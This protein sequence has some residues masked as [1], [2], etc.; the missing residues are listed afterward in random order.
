MIDHQKARA[1]GE[2]VEWV[3]V[4]D[5]YKAIG[6][7]VRVATGVRETLAMLRDA[8]NEMSRFPKVRYGDRILNV[9]YSPLLYDERRVSREI[10]ALSKKGAKY[11]VHVSPTCM[12]E[13]R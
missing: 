4:P 5:G 12:V 13:P 10:D 1:T 6:R 3:A 8:A 7:P 2:P 11:G 9:L